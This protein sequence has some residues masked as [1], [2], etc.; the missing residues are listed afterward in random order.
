MRV[1]QA[2]SASS[3]RAASY[4]WWPA[5][6][7]GAHRARRARGSEWATTICT[8]DQGIPHNPYRKP[9]DRTNVRGSAAASGGDRAR[10]LDVAVHL[11]HERLHA[12]EAPLAAQ[13]CQEREPDLAVVEV[14]VEVEQV[15]LDQHATTRHE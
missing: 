6:S 13:A 14:A 15:G 12:V 9:P 5:R 4:T 3:P 1:R 7:S 10:R 2:T 11:L 8:A